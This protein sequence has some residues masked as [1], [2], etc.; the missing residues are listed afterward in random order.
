MTTPIKKKS[1]QKD[2]LEQYLQGIPIETIA[3]N[4]NKNKN[5]I[6]KW[7]KRFGWEKYRNQKRDNGQSQKILHSR[8]L[9]NVCDIQATYRF[10]LKTI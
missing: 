10:T 5:T 2:A 3:R 6:H 4:L 1:I 9:R 7:K 8:Y